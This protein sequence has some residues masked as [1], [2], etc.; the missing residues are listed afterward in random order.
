MEINDMYFKPAL[1]E[2]DVDG[3]IEAVD[4]YR[5]Y[6]RFAHS[7]YQ[8]LNA[9]SGEMDRLRVI[10]A[11]KQAEYDLLSQRVA[12]G[13]RQLSSDVRSTNTVIKQDEQRLAEYDGARK[14]FLY[15]ALEMYAKLLTH[16]NADDDAVFRLVSLWF[17]HHADDKLNLHLAKYLSAIPSGNFVFLAH[18]LSARLCKSGSGSARFESNLKDL[19]IRIG[20]QHPFHILYQVYSLRQ[21]SGVALFTQ[22]GKSRPDRTFQASPA[23]SAQNGRRQ[24]AEDVFS[25]LRK[26]ARVGERVRHLETACEAFM[27]LALA[28]PEGKGKGPYK[29]PKLKI[30]KLENVPIPVPTADL[31]V[32]PTC[33]YE[34]SSMPCIS[35]FA[36]TYNLAGGIHFP[37]IIDC[38][39]SDGRKY[40]GLVRASM[41]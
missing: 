38:Y 1:A 39:G 4:I 11:H 22:K 25:R 18:Q 26:D 7:Q 36:D 29:V 3:D 8:A 17:S 24:V 40:K 32:D 33:A 19:V 12:K 21:T 34:P 5:R 14:R 20:R 13:D 41:R 2:V 31:A 6:A 27:E 28:S 30:R 35:R 15:L 10:R 37:K 23:S 9:R 16:S